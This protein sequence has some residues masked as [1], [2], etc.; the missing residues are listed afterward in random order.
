[1]HVEPP[2]SSANA[3]VEAETPTPTPLT[4]QGPRERAPDQTGGI[5]NLDRMSMADIREVEEQMKRGKRRV[6]EGAAK[7]RSAHGE[8][9]EAVSERAQAGCWEPSH[10][11]QCY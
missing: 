11:S 10:R 7:I 9:D 1:M 4:P 5:Y 2:G 8:D 3:E 6:C